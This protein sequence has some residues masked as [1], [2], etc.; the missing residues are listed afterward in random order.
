MS[1]SQVDAVARGRVWSGNA[2]HRNGLVDRLGSFTS[3]LARARELSHLG[4][5]AE[6]VIRPERP[7]TL[8]EYILNSGTES[9][10]QR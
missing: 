9:A 3:A 7:Q 5:T 6:V 4:P 10:T 8:L 2:A 1:L